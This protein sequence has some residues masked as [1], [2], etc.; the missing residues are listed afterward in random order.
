MMI[1]LLLC[2][3][4]LPT[5]AHATVDWDEGFEYSGATIADM[6]TSMTAANW[7][8]SCPGNSVIIAPTT[9]ALA[10]SGAPA[11]HGGT[12]MLEERFR[13]HQGVT[14]GYQSCFID[15]ALNASTTDTLYSRFWFYLPSSFQLDPTVTKMTLHP[16]YAS[17]SYTSM[18]WTMLWGSPQLEVGVQKVWN[19]PILNDSTENIYGG[20][21]PRDQWVCI[22][23]RLTYATPGQQNGIV[24]AW[25]NEVQSINRTNVW[26]DQAGQ[27]S[28]FR[29]IRLYT[30]DGV[31]QLYYD[32]YAVSRDARIG[33]GSA[34]SPPSDTIAPSVPT[35]VA[36]SATVPL[37]NSISW[38]ASTDN[39]GVSDYTVSY[40]T[41]AACTPSL[42][43][44]TTSSTGLAHTG[45]T[46]GTVYGY[47]VS[48]RDAAGNI[49][50]NSSI[51]YV[52]ALSSGGATSLTINSA[53]KFVLNGTQQFI[54]LVSMFDALS[55]TSAD[56]DSVESYGA[57]GVRI[58]VNWRDHLDG[59]QSVC[60]ATGALNAGRAATLETLLDDLESRNLVT[61]IVILSENSST[62]MTTQAERLTCVT[63]VVNAVEHHPLILIDVVQEY[64]VAAITWADELTELKLYTDAARAACAA[65]LIG[66]S[67]TSDFP[68]GTGI[69]P[70]DT[71][72]A[73][74][75][76]NKSNISAKLGTNGESYLAVHDYR[77]SNWYSI[78]GARATAYLNYLASI[79]RQATP[80]LFDEPCR[81]NGY[82]AECDAATASNYI[83]A[84]VDFKAAGGALY[85]V[86]TQAGFDLGTSRFAAQLTVKEA[87]VFAGV[88]SA[89]ATPTNTTPVVLE[90]YDFGTALS[91]RMTGGIETTD[92]PAITSGRLRANNTATQSV[93][94]Y[95][96]T[97][98]TLTSLF[99]CTTANAGPPPSASFLTLSGNGLKVISNQCGQD[100]ASTAGAEDSAVWNTDFTDD[101]VLQATLA[102]LP[103]DST[104]DQALMGIRVQATGGGYDNMYELEIDRPSGTWR[105]RLYRLS[106]GAYTQLGTTETSTVTAGDVFKLEAV[107]STIT[108]SQNGTAI[109]TSTDST[110]T[111][112]G[113]LH[114][115]S[116]RATT[117]TSVRWTNI[118]GGNYT[119]GT[120]IPANHGITAEVP[121]A[122]GS[123]PL[124]LRLGVRMQ[125]G[126]DY[127]GY[128]CRFTY[129]PDT[130]EITRK[131]NDNPVTIAGPVSATLT[132]GD[133]LGCWANGSTVYATQGA[134]GATTLLSTTDA[135]YSSG[136]PYV[137]LNT[138][139]EALANLE[140]DNLTIYE[141]GAAAPPCTPSI[142]AVVAS[143]TGATVTYDSACPPTQIRI[144]TELDTQTLTLSSFPGGVYTRPGGWKIG[145]NFTC[146]RAFD[147]Q[148]VV[149]DTTYG[150]DG[151]SE[152]VPNPDNTAPTMTFVGPTG[153]LPNGTTS[154]VTSFTTDEAA[155]CRWATTNI[156]YTAM[157]TLTNAFGLSHSFTATGLGTGA[158]AFYAQC[159]D[160]A[161]QPNTTST[162]L[163]ITITVAASTADVTAPTTVTNLVATAISPSQITITHDL[164][165]D[166]GGAPSYAA[167]LS[168][169]GSTYGLAL[170]Y[171]GVPQTIAG[172]SPGTLYYVKVLSID[173]SLNPAAAY[174]NVATATTNAVPDTEVP[175]DPAGLVITGTYSQSATIA[176]TPGSDNSGGVKTAVEICS[177]SAACT[178]FS[179]IGT[180]SG[181][182]YT[183]TGL[184]ASTIYR[185]RIKHVD[186]T[187]NV[188]ANYS[189]RVNF[190][191]TASTGNP[192]ILPRAPVSFSQPRAPRVP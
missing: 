141:Y 59:T 144:D 89:L 7:S 9:Q 80:L 171:T 56:L 132:A 147:A 33:C 46:G 115:A 23:T 184:T 73:L 79:G 32:D 3:L 47:R 24:Q 112:G 143:S 82:S 72:S 35:G 101:Q 5:L 118:S 6:N 123:N 62:L 36:A 22:E 129:N 125:T 169:D 68:D 20:I 77:S 136:K 51:V 10:Q 14:P 121:T 85:V 40:C 190:T 61:K 192:L 181:T 94:V 48:A 135:T 127:S 84:A 41:G 126:T 69:A 148:G 27:Q 108:V 110:F 57:N 25:I 117:P 42:T 34:P 87:T 1:R 167:Y 154:A 8:T 97:T 78:T 21:I 104:P 52:T 45:L 188:S 91:T 124:H 18:W 182:T 152:F 149:N 186:D 134:A 60:E 93:A 150:C 146:M 17:D 13:G 74:T 107:G 116:I 99:T 172:L 106:S 103:A 175:S 29:A 15:R 142:S 128:D 88:A 76:A 155:A 98:V 120:T 12:R 163:T 162:A 54:W 183:I 139:G 168:Q 137:Y 100:G 170:T 53:G 49:S 114:I 180:G 130:V 161:P 11:P 105:K 165:T 67:G 16:A 2:L 66:A 157:S 174:S 140:V 28:V 81:D 191:T 102:A 96:G 39:L 122:T 30:Q 160:Q 71:T 50:G 156:A 83:Q 55:I 159:Q 177:G 145:E 131:D 164:S 173:P 113:Y 158:N 75:A 86:H 90:T 4:L 19:P 166:A 133:V 109:I 38:T 187:G 178:A 58:F 179:L 37:Q 95:N 26:M 70:Q 151:V 153:E 43:A 119:A 92:T 31:G 65:C 185:V 176:W 63:N 64:N 44:G 138:A 189:E 111:T